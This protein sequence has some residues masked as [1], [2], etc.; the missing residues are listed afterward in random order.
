MKTFWVGGTAPC[1]LD[2]GTRRR[3]IVCIMPWLQTP[4][5]RP[6][7]QLDRKLGGPQ[8]HGKEKNS[9]PP[10]GIEPQS[11]MPQ[12]VTILTELPW[13]WEGGGNTKI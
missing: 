5:K 12:P 8:N 4:R 13:L 10:P 3:R 7:Y 9:Q 11:S 1:I 6:Q 2:L